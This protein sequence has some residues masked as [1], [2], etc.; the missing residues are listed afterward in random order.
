MRTLTRNELVAEVM[1]RLGIRGIF[2]RCSTEI[3]ELVAEMI[4]L[5]RERV[6][7]CYEQRTP[8]RTCGGNGYV[9]GHAC[10]CQGRH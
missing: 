6:P 5:S 4:D 8:C 7:E 10:E 3:V 1:Y 9:G 2:G